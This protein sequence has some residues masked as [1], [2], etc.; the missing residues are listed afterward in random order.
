MAKQ[1]FEKGD[2]RINRKGRKAG[3]PNKSTNELRMLVQDFIEHNWHTLQKSFDK[4]DDKD[5]L[6]FIEK[7]LK[8]TLPAPLTELERMTDAQLDAFI[9]KVK[10]QQ[11]EAHTQTQN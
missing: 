2:A 10:Q 3:T 9:Q 6:N 11:H 5:K 7:L 8:H 4:L 1:Q